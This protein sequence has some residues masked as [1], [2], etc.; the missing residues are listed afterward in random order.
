MLLRALVVKGYW[1]LVVLLWA[2][3][4][5]LLVIG[6]GWFIWRSAPMQRLR[7]VAPTA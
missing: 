7:N 1:L 2:A 4:D 6:V 5:N 3:S